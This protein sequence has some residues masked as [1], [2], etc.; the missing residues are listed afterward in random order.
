MADA[1]DTILTFGRHKGERLAEVPDDYLAWLSAKAFSA[2]MRQAA[3]AVRELAKERARMEEAR[4]RILAQELLDDIADGLTGDA[5][6][7]TYESLRDPRSHMS[8]WAWT[9]PR[10]A[11]AER[12]RRDVATK[13]GEYMFYEHMIPSLRRVEELPDGRVRAVVVKN[14]Y[15]GD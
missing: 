7:A 1:A 8:Q 14:N 12:V 3:A 13:P 5:D 6:D 11:V 2:E 4:S 10:G 15:A 9:G